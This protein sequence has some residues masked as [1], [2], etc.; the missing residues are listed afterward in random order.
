MAS[1]LEDVLTAL[2]GGAAPAA[3]MP[4]ASPFPNVTA[5]PAPL[6][7]AALWDK[8]AADEAAAN[9]AADRRNVAG[10]TRA[11]IS[12]YM[13]FG[14]PG[15]DS[16]GI[17][18]ALGNSPAGTGV[19]G[20]VAVPGAPDGS[21]FGGVPD[22]SQ[23]N[24]TTIGGAPRPDPVPPSV[25]TAKAMTYPP[26][27]DPMTAG[28]QG[29]A[30]AAPVAT[31]VG[32]ARRAAPAAA[33]MMPVAPPQRPF[34]ERLAD[35]GPGLIGI[36]S[37]LSGEGSGAA[38]RQGLMRQKRADEDLSRNM[39]AQ[40]LLAR[41]APQAEVAAAVRSPEV[42]KSMI[43]KYGEAK[44]AQ[45]VNGRLV[46]ERPDGTVETLADF[47]DEK[48]KAP[49][50]R[51]HKLPDGS[52][53]RQEWVRGAWR[54]VGAPAPGERDKRLSVTDITKL[55]EEGGK[56]TQIRG[57]Q[58]GFRPEY[59]GW[60]VNAIG[61]M[62]NTAGRNLPESMVGKDRAAAAGWWQ[63]YDRYKNMVRHELFGSALTGTE[64]KAFVAA[65]IT[66]GMTPEQVSRNLA[67]QRRVV[68]GAIRRKG[69]GLIGS[70]YDKGAIAAAY[71]VDPGFFDAA[72]EPAPS[73]GR[74]GTI[75]MGDI[76]IPWSLKQ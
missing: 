70:T 73:R 63:D 67:T 14:V 72:D 65:D 12:Q 18:L 24:M 76:S 66:P 74:S 41:G 35:L 52:V 61:D 47:H 15:A 51:E 31:D 36:G 37:I 60:K 1:W 54:D 16:A 59:A 40:W 13:P 2:Q 75:K 44:Q 23:F 19:P 33:P 50:Q 46:R 21:V 26:A 11:P 6:E 29:A 71:G 7:G 32:A 48:D 68:E 38:E 39:T 17:N 69:K 10:M 8:I 27:G 25:Q 57:F 28:G 34:A 53:Q 5:A 4:P 43:T 62:M 49:T 30:P 9:A 3:F 45:V 20:P 58:E 56:L 64:Q 22:L 55:S 42:L